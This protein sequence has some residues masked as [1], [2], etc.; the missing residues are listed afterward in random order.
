MNNKDLPRW[1]INGRSGAETGNFSL[2]M[3]AFS[4]LL[5]HYQSIWLIF[6]AFMNHIIRPVV[7]KS[8]IKSRD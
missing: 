1:W 7:Y 6:V 3:A 2:F 5:G 8:T 4:P